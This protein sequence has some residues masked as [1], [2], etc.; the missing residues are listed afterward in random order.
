MRGLREGGGNSG[1]KT[2]KKKVTKPREKRSDF[3]R[4]RKGSKETG[5]HLG[6]RA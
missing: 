5:V 4:S 2:K 3:V 6:H 1:K